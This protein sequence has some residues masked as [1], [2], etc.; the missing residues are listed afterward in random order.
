M[1]TKS[2]IFWLAAIVA[3]APF[4]SCEDYLE[5]GVPDSQLS[6][7]NV[8]ADAG[9]AQAALL[10]VYAKLRNTSLLPGDTGGIGLMLGNAADELTCY[11]N[12][13][14]PEEYFF[15]NGVLPANP[16]VTTWWNNSYNV[17]YSANSVMEGL[18]ESDG[19]AADTKDRLYGEALF[20]RTLVHF[21]LLNLYGDVPYV[22]TT[23]YRQNAAIG[24]MTPEMLYPILVA[25]L[26]T[27][28]GLLPDDYPSE[29]RTRA[30][31][32]TAI[33][34]LAKMY[35]Y[36]G[37]YEQA[38]TQATLVIENPAYPWNDDLAT[39][40]LKDSPSTIWQLQPNYAGENTL[41]AVSYIF[42][43]GPP[44]N[45]AMSG[46]LANAFEAGDLRFAQWVGSVT[47]GTDTWY[48]PYKYKAQDFT[49]SSQ[50]YSIV[51][52]LEELYLIRAEAFA[53]QGNLAA[54][55]QDV[56]KIRVRAGLAEVFPADQQEMLTA[57][58]QER[59]IELFC[60]HGQRWFDL[61]RLGLSDAVLGPQKPGWDATDVLLPLPETELQL[62]PNLLPQNP[63]Y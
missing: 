50:E 62:N 53:M 45:R 18:E 37:L 25:D 30:N 55:A 29:S 58:V 32:S 14:S 15:E 35:L 6:S 17:I 13:N 4:Y 31:K 59:R 42:F 23:D 60:E 44:P 36:M 8:F 51:T 1:K 57:I 34:L 10:D 12:T 19:I 61:K 49:D 48:Y 52:R 21:Y 47:D 24:K 3:A 56:N 33:A 40:F 63:G 7:G 43:S 38:Q 11:G 39:V 26:Q 54:A 46:S 28:I 9:T 41:E 22:P 2:F 16:Q 27:A 20:L 5:V